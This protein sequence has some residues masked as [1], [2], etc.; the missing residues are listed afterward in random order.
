MYYNT[1]IFVNIIDKSFSYILLSDSIEKDLPLC[2][3]CISTYCGCWKIH[4][5]T[6][7][8]FLVGRRNWVLP[9]VMSKV[10][11]KEYLLTMHILFLNLQKYVLFFGLGLFTCTIWKH[12]K[13]S[14][15]SINILIE[16]NLVNN[17]YFILEFAEVCTV[18]LGWVC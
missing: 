5:E 2:T 6:R 16:E 7:W 14:K 12:Y 9:A 8:P 13:Y 18:F 15:S 11:D 4:K 10:A 3:A 1:Y 17:A